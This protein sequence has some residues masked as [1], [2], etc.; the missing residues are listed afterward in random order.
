MGAGKPPKKELLPYEWSIP[1]QR[2][3]CNRMRTRGLL[4]RGSGPFVRPNLNRG[5]TWRLPVLALATHRYGRTRGS[6]RGGIRRRSAQWAGSVI[7]GLRLGG[8]A[9]RA[10]RGVQDQRITD[11]RHIVM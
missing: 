7:G 10:G 6:L 1:C 9:R 2:C 4:I 5:K 3:F 8:V 11:I